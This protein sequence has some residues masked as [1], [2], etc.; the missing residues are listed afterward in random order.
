MKNTPPSKVAS[1]NRKGCED[2]DLKN[3]K[4]IEDLVKAQRVILRDFV[5]S[6]L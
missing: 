5:G 1:Y 2:V 4:N 6:L 3:P